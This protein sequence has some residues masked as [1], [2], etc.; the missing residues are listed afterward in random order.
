MLGPFGEFP[1][2]IGIPRDVTQV[3]A[4]GGYIFMLY[5]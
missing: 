3:L 5:L 2:F 4:F 1:S